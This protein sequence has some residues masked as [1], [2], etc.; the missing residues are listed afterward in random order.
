MMAK[1]PAGGVDEFGKYSRTKKKPRFKPLLTI[2]GRRDADIATPTRDAV[3]FPRI[4]NATPGISM[5]RTDQLQM[6]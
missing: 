2:G 6:E 3:L 4:D 1:S 5:M